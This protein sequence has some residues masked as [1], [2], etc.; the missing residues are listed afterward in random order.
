VHD[1][2]VKAALPENE[3]CSPLACEGLLSLSREADP[4]K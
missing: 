3:V 4:S 1:A 2:G